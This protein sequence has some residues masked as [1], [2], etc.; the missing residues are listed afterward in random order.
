RPRAVLAGG[1]S[2]YGG[3]MNPKRKTTF[4]LDTHG[5]EIACVELTRGMTA[6]ILKADYDVITADGWR[7]WY[8]NTDGKGRLYPSIH[9]TDRSD[10]RKAPI[11]V[12]RLITKAR[13][14]DRVTYRDRN[15]MNLLPENLEMI[16]RK[17]HRTH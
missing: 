8:A 16:C 13:P 6:I 10:G 5:R 4:D 14:G 17:E 1:F 12:A 9:P 2:L 15:P 7:N 3:H 11:S